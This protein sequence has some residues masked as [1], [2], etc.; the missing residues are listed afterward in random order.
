MKRET[1]LH[2]AALLSLSIIMVSCAGSKQAAENAFYGSESITFTIPESS[3]FVWNETLSY[4]E[5]GKLNL[6]V[7]DARTGFIE[8]DYQLFQP[9]E[10]KKY[11]TGANLHNRNISNVR[12]KLTL[13]FWQLDE[14]KTLLKVFTDAEVYEKPTNYRNGGW[15]FATSNGSFEKELIQAIQM[16]TD[17]AEK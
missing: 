4:L 3:E 17:I 7:S 15:F 8:T 11:I 16:K 2:V 10:F 6:S 1:M 5:N 13:Y 9:A 14:N 12:I